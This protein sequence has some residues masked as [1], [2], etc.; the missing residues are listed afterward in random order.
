LTH[1]CILVSSKFYIN[2]RKVVGSLTD[3]SQIWRIS[4][5]EISA[6]ATYHLL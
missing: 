5:S 4:K 3:H 2:Q 1:F 6:L